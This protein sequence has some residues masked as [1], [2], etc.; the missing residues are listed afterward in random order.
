MMVFRRRFVL[1]LRTDLVLPTVTVRFRRTLKLPE[2]G[3]FLLLIISFLPKRTRRNKL[4]QHSLRTQNVSVL[5]TVRF[6]WDTNCIFKYDT[7]CIFKYDTLEMQT[8][9]VKICYTQVIIIII[10]VI[11]PLGRFGQRPELSQSTG[12]ALVRCILGK[13]LGAVCHCFPPH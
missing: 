7:N 8:R 9:S 5:F 6:P 3:D 11:Q 4:T 10:I 1:T 13:F 2:R 12:I